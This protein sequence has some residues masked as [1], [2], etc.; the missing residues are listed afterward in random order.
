MFTYKFSEYF[1]VLPEL[2]KL[3]ELLNKYCNLKSQNQ[4]A[5]VGSLLQEIRFW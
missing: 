1:A 2:P 5:P 3:T 4:I